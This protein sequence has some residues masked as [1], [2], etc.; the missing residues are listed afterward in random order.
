MRI[1]RNCSK[2]ET[3]RTRTIEYKGYLKWQNYGS[4]LVDKQFD[5]ALQIE[6]SELLKDKVKSNKNIFPLVIDFN[7]LFPNISQIVHKQDSF[8]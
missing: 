1:N 5:K 7:R 8:T 2:E 3:C 4:D 6:R